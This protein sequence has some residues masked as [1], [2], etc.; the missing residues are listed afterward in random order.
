MRKVLSSL[1]L[2]SLLV[3]GTHADAREASAK[4]QRAPDSARTQKV[5]DQQLIDKMTFGYGII[6]NTSQQI[7][8]Y[9]ALYQG[10]TSA[11]E[12]AQTVNDETKNPGGCGMA[13]IAFLPGDFL[14]TVNVTGGQMRM[15]QIVVLAMKTEKGW[16]RVPPTLQ[17][18][19]LFVKLDE[20]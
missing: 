4:T 9:L 16:E 10:R 12:A 18:T 3:L 13:S 20:A 6:C 8:R 7:Q 2:G 14:G 1:A 5:P 19:A 17:Y 15:L 11:E